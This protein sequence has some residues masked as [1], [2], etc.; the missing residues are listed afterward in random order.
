MKVLLVH[1]YYRS[2]KPSGENVVY[3]REKSLLQERSDLDL[4]CYERS[5]DEV[6]K[7]SAIGKATFLKNLFFDPKVYQ[8]LRALLLE[9][10]PDIVHVHNTFPLISSAVFKAAKDLKIPVVQTLHNYRIFCANGACVRNNKACDLC[11]ET[12]N[13]WNGV[14]HACYVNSRV[15]SVPMV[16][17]I[18]KYQDE[19]VWTEEIDHFIALSEFARSKFV[20]AGIPKN[21]ITI[22]A[23]F[24][25]DNGLNQKANEEKSGFLFVGRFSEDKGPHIFLEAAQKAKVEAR[26]IG[27]G[28]MLEHLKEKYK[29]EE[30]I[31]FLGSKS[32]QDVF[33]EMDNAI[34]LVLPSLCFEGFPLTIAEAFSRSLPIIAS[35]IGSISE[36]IERG[37]TG[38]KFEPGNSDALAQIL[39]DGAVNPLPFF[40]MG[41]NARKEY[42]QKFSPEATLPQL[43]S[44]YN[45][46]V[47]SAT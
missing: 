22:K 30:H 6:A 10:K 25:E 5:T 31:K 4:I 44:I 28:P 8:E 34:A 23:N 7:M 19:N 13:L 12:G 20:Q 40:D 11:L 26:L 3:E 35:D 27:D 43:L 38:A 45:S 46:L 24:C 39:V 29:N 42:E 21:R 17:M 36:R 9:E 1:N 15:A 14:K 47:K 18:K 33:R 2:H 37:V 41:L 16:N 32:H